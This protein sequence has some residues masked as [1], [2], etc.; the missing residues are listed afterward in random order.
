MGRSPAAV[1]SRGAGDVN[2]AVFSLSDRA[3]GGVSERAGLTSAPSLMAAIGKGGN[4]S[5]R[6]GNATGNER[7]AGS[8]RPSPA[9]GAG[10]STGTSRTTTGTG[11]SSR[12]AATGAVGTKIDGTASS[13]GGAFGRGFS[14]TPGNSVCTD[15]EGTTRRGRA[16]AGFNALA[17]A[18]LASA[19]LASAD[20]A[21]AGLASAGL[22]SAGL[23]ARIFGRSLGDFLSPAA[24]ED[25]SLEDL[26][27]WAMSEFSG[28]RTEA[29]PP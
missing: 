8:D 6:G 3:A 9:N 7:S 27:D 22:A 1:E 23:A 29:T 17:S 10:R 12:G 16:F 18:G 28:N 19:D 13:A 5:G 24:R 25:A 2:S 26:D 15:L 4:G 20:L 11:R 21:S 14:V